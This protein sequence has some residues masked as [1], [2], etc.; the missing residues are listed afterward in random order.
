MDY[1]R[2]VEFG[3][4]VAPNSS[5]MDAIRVAVTAAAVLAY[6]IILFWLPLLVGSVT[7]VSLRRG[8]NRPDRPDLC[9]VPAAS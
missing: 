4:S 6:R 8:L 9:V 3:I 7:F 5:E 2:P 1:G